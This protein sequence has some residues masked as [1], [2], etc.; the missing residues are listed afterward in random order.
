MYD[1]QSPILDFYP[2]DFKLDLNGK[3]FAWMGMSALLVRWG[4]PLVACSPLQEI[5]HPVRC[6]TR[7]VVAAACRCRAAAVHRREA[8]AE[9]AQ[10]CLR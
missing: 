8:A 2:T 6:L 4:L 5:L 7:I 3:R 1:E 10:E 9:C